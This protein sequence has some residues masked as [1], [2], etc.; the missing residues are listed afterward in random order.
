M[1][2]YWR[3]P[4]TRILATWKKFGTFT[5]GW[6]QLGGD[7]CSER[8]NCS[9]LEDTEFDLHSVNQDYEPVLTRYYTKLRN[10]TETGFS[11][12]QCAS[13]HQESDIQQPCWSSSLLLAILTEWEGVIVPSK[14]HSCPSTASYV[15]NSFYSR[16]MLGQKRTCDE[17]NQTFKLHNDK[18]SKSLPRLAPTWD[19][20]ENFSVRVINTTQGHTPG[21]AMR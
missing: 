15:G 11:Q 14:T 18:Q 20:W 3:W 16:W 21:Y 2:A 4:I 19:N 10:I 6:T 13:Y 7:C 1:I 8:S 12:E 5:C 9:K 17:R